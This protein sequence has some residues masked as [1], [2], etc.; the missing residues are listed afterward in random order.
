MNKAEY[1]SYVCIHC[2]AETNATEVAAALPDEVLIAETARR[3][4]RRQTP[5]AGPGRPA[6]VRCPGCDG[7]MSSA[8]LRE[9]R[10]H[11]VARRLNDLLR[12]NLD[13]RLQPKDPDPYPNFRI[14]C[15]SEDSI[16]FV[17]LSSSQY[18]TVET[19]K[20][21]EIAVSS[22]EKIAYIRLLG[23]VC[24]EDSIQRWQF[25]A[26]VVGRPSTTKESESQWTDT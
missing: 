10:L 17:K 15:A 8:E 9:H 1:F 19:R 18:L 3:N 11:C 4:G 26:T 25:R 12:L 2:R 22:D 24:W 21:A 16:E 14:R 7:E 5:H 6:I 23:R 13:I 20:I